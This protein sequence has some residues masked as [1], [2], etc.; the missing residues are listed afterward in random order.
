L[1]LHS[2]KFGRKIVDRVTLSRSSSD[3]PLDLTETFGQQAQML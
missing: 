3:F 2:P 1:N